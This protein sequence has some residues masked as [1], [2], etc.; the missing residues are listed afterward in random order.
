[1]KIADF[2]LFEEIAD[3]DMP[4]KG[5]RASIALGYNRNKTSAFKTP[6]GAVIE[7][8]DDV[9]LY[10]GLRQWVRLTDG[11]PER[12]KASASLQLHKIWDRESAGRSK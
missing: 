8:G 1:M 7:V 11:E 12:I 5:V 4:T 6:L 2:S 3:P 10:N 9:Y